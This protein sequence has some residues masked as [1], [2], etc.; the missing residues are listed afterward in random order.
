[1]LKGKAKG[2]DYK[3]KITPA[4]TFASGWTLPTG[5][6]AG[7]KFWLKVQCAIGPAIGH[8]RV[9]A[10]K[11][12]PAIGP[13]HYCYDIARS[14]TI[15]ICK[16]DPGFEELQQRV[17]QDGVM[18]VKAHF[19]AYIDADGDCFVDTSKCEIKKW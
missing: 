14:T 9:S 7:E 16:G 5:V 15:R 11:S 18:E 12:G 3:P 19:K 8:D 4:P 2:T 10:N 6:N 17:K 1:M 13:E